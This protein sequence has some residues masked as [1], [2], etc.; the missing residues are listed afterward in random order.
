MQRGAPKA[1]Y[2]A[3]L[4]PGLLESTPQRAPRW[5]GTHPKDGSSQMGLFPQPSVIDADHH[6]GGLDDGVHLLA[7]GES[8]FRG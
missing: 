5:A 6:A 8:E 2:P 1:G 7:L 3:E 4:G